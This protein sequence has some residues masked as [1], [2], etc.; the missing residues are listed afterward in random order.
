MKILYCGSF[1]ETCFASAAINRVLVALKHEVINIDPIPYFHTNENFLTKLQLHFLMG[2]C[3]NTYNK[4][5][6]L[7]AHKITP[8][9]VFTDQAF[10]LFPDTISKLKSVCKYVVNYTTEYLAFHEQ[11]YKHFFKAVKFYDFHII[12]NSLN[13]PILEKKGVKKIIRTEFCY[14]P[15]VHCPLSLTEND[16]EKYKSEVAFIGHWE[17]STEKIISYLLQNNVPVRVWGPFWVRAKS[18][19]NKKTVFPLYEIDYVKA[20]SASKICLCILSK[21]NHNQSTIRTFE[22]PAI[23]SFMLAERTGEHKSYFEEGKEAEYFSTL[24]ELIEKI[25]YYLKNEEERKLIAARGR[26]RCITSGYTYQDRLRKI[27]SEI[28]EK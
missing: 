23:G 5:V 4:D 22:I 24:D 28:T 1:S 17:P 12:T 26:N 25:K 15:G 20:I 16:L 13:V 9:L 18:L 21:Q 11:M 7:L 27:L 2:P 19:P 3:I 6:L 14:D 10:L 8:D